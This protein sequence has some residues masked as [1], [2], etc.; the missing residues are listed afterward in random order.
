MCHRRVELI[1]CACSSSE[2]MNG[3]SFSVNGV[4]LTIPSTRLWDYTNG[5]CT[6]LVESGNFGF[7][8]L[9]NVFLDNFY[10]LFNMDNKS[11]SLAPSVK[12]NFDAIIRNNK[13]AKF[14]SFFSSTRTNLNSYK[15]E[16]IHKIKLSKNPKFLFLL[17][18]I[19]Q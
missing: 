19:K 11:V 2:E 4:E 9:G 16:I 15:K 10:V 1:K 17:R 5:N 13:N 8:I 7:W 14:D 12:L 3:I 6:L 18:T